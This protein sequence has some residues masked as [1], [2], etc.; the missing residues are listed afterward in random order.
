MVNDL[1]VHIR[2]YMVS[3]SH[4][5]DLERAEYIISLERAKENEQHG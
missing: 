1:I 2:P 5:R 4:L 3:A